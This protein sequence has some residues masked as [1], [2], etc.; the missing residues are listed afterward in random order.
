[1]VGIEQG[2]KTIWFGRGQY[3]WFVKAVIALW[4]RG[5]TFNLVRK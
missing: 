5:E 1:M 4:R 2:G 3:Q